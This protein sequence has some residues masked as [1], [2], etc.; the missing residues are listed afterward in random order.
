MEE[1]TKILGAEDVV[2][3]FVE[4]TILE[5]GNGY[6]TIRAVTKWGGSCPT[7]AAKFTVAIGE[8]T[9]EEEEGVR[10][11]ILTGDLYELS[12]EEFRSTVA[13][14][15]LKRL[16]LTMREHAFDAGLNNLAFRTVEKLPPI[17]EA[18]TPKPAP[19]PIVR[20]QN[21]SGTGDNVG[22]NQVVVG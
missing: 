2:G 5:V 17:Q 18:P 3:L 8:E 7:A 10:R 9:D 12:V 19:V 21:H 4:M 11:H 1:G 13:P 22:G 15:L 16:G 6:A 14:M 20:T